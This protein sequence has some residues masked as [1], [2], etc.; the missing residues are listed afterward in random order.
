MPYCS[1]FGSQSQEL[2]GR[3]ILVFVDVCSYFITYL[4][5]FFFS[6][7]LQFLL[8]IL[9]LCLYKSTMIIYSSIKWSE[10]KLAEFISS[11]QFWE[12]ILLASKWK[13]WAESVAKCVLG[14]TEAQGWHTHILLAQINLH[15][16][17][18]C[19][20]VVLVVLC[21]L[22]LCAIVNFRTNIM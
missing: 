5:Q 18:L 13:R 21:Y 16:S 7:R 9:G 3:C 15:L 4:I 1:G 22:L 14:E 11:N 12:A 2:S 10:E 8:P 19:R 20:G 17:V 6:F